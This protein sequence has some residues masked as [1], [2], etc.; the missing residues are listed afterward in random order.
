M[1][2]DVEGRRGGRKGQREEEETQ[3][4]RDRY[5]YGTDLKGLQEDLFFFSFYKVE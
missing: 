2:I 4:D 3:R 5:N 1:L